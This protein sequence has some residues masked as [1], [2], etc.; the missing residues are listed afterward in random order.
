MF[1]SF[2]IPSIGTSGQFERAVSPTVHWGNVD[3]GSMVN[4]LYS[5]VLAGFPE[6]S[7]FKRDFQHEVKGVGNKTTQVICKLTHVPVSIGAEQEKG[8]CN[9]TTFYVLDCPGYHFILGLT[10]L[11]KIDAAVFCST[12]RMEFRLGTAGGNKAH[13]IPLV[14][15]SHVK[16][17]PAYLT[18]HIDPHVH[19][20]E[21]TTI[22]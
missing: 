16:L 10:L 15:R 12:R 11:Q 17:T 9:T 20:Q 7:K 4:I 14:P 5:G 22:P 8:S 19:T 3:T 2:T 21:L 6:L 18:V 13:S 1:A